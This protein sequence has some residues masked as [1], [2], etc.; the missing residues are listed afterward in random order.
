[1]EQHVYAFRIKPGF[2][3]RVLE[4]LAD[5]QIAVGWSKAK[6]LL[7]PQLDRKDFRQ[8]LHEIYYSDLPNFRRS[9]SAVTHTWRFIR[10]LKRG[11]IVIIPRQETIHL[12]KIDDDRAIYR[13]DMLDDDTSIRRN[14]VKLSPGSPISYSELSPELREALAFQGTS[15]DLNNFRDE[16]LELI[17]IGQLSFEEAGAAVDERADETAKNPDY[18]L[19]QTRPEQARFRQLLR[20]I[21]GNRCCLS[22]TALPAT[23]QAAHIIPHREGGP[24]IN[25]QRN[26]LLLRADIHLL[27]D[28][29]LLTVDP[30]KMEVTL[31]DSVKNTQEYQHLEGRK[32]MSRADPRLMA[33]HYNRFQ[34]RHGISRCEVTK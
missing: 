6:R 25:H 3:D 15:A 32:I 2:R 21:Y 17:D 30:E 27:F 33:V 4:V 11:D 12:V 23:L 26:G 31:A 22:G 20:D 29:L 28:A 18:A 9:G 34:D 5:D 10:E 19:V 8:I 16:I 7:E 13:E 1:M 24:G 14:I